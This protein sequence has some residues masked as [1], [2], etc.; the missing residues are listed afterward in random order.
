M[1]INIYKLIILVADGTYEHISI[2]KQITE[3][4]RLR[5]FNK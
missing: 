5:N 4:G 1:Q 2:R 3:N